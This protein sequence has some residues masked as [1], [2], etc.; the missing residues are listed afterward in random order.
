MRR[1]AVVNEWLQ[2]PV[3]AW[4]VVVAGSAL[5]IFAGLELPR[6]M[7]TPS[8]GY[9]VIGDVPDCRPKTYCLSRTGTFTSDDRKL[10]DKS[11]RMNDTLDPSFR[12]GDSVRAFDIGADEVFTQTKGKGFKH[13]WPIIGTIVGLVVLAMGLTGLS[14]QRARPNAKGPGAIEHQ[15]PEY[16]PP[17][18]NSRNRSQDRGRRA[19]R[20]RRRKR[21]RTDPT[22]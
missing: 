16:E 6:A 2:N 22:Q 15:V 4:A 11:V 8:P 10:I 1:A 20:R 14:Q 17:T 12:K 21:A 19:R 9:Y 5:L 3:V 18:G 7:V 13:E